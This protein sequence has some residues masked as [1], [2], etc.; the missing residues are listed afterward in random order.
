MPSDNSSEAAAPANIESL[1]DRRLAEIDALVKAEDFAA[2]ERLI[3]SLPDL[4]AGIP[5][6]SR[7][8][9]L[10]KIQDFL[11]G[12]H[13]QAES[14]SERIRARLQTLKSG[15]VANSAYAAASRLTTDSPV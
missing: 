11:A 15:R 14:K 5:G 7:E 12:V 8:A 10:L 4:A 1:V 6:E 2:I 13:S 9:V 3:Q